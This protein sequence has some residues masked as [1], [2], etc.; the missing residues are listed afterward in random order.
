MLNEAKTA[1]RVTVNH[2]DGEIMSLLQAGAKDL[3]I[4]GVRVPGRIAWTVSSG[5]V[6]DQSDLKDP[7]VKRA[8]FTYA[9]MMF[10]NPPNY[11]KLKESYDNQK[12]QLMHASGYTDYKDGGDLEC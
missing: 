9:A 12:C 10:G 4:A 1:L 8:I 6:V 7:L 11:D 2:F 5:A 3:Q